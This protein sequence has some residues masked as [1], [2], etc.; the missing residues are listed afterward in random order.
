VSRAR[1]GVLDPRGRGVVV[2]GASSGLGADCALHLDRLGFRVF[3]G[4][5]KEADGERLAAASTGALTPLHLDVTDEAGI[6]RAAATVDDALA[7]RRLW[8]LVNNAGIVVPSPLA[9]LD[10]NRFREQLETGLVGQLAVI[11]AFL[12]LLAAPGG[13]DGGRILNVTSGLG[14]VGVPFLGAYV[15]SQFAK[16]GL[17]DVLRREVAP[18]GVA[19]SVVRTGAIVTPMWEKAAADAERAVATAP[20]GAV[21]D[22]RAAFR[23]FMADN[24]RTA[25]ASGTTPADFAGTVATALT[26]RRPRIRYAV[27]RDAAAA[28]F[29]RLV[30]AAVL[31]RQ[32]RGVVSGD[33]AVKETDR[34]RHD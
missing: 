30:P 34:V 21:G 29:A 13:R 8:G 23:R 16:E 18:L 26:T 28:A 5:R 7:G 14:S 32:F 25:R 27:G 33:R 11:R 2:T 22:Y 20:A 31:D 4:V 17:S 12:P 9:W 1:R 19:V 24:E 15:A 6:A 10:S 3:A